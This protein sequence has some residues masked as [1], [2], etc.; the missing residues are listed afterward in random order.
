MPVTVVIA[1]YNRADYLP[2]AIDSALAQSYGPLEIIVVDDGS[3]DATR[4][5]AMRYGASVTYVWQSN[6]ERGA[7]RNHG[8]RRAQGEL[9]VFLDSDD[10]WVPE[11]LGRDIDVLRQRPEVGL[12]YSDT[13]VVDAARQPLRRVRRRGHEGWVTTALMRENFV[14]PSTAVIRTALMREIGGFLE[15]RE[16][17]GAEDWE[18]WVRLSTRTQFGYVAD[19]TTWYRVHGGNSVGSAARVEGATHRAYATMSGAT[20]LTAEHRHYLP[21]AFAEAALL[22]A[23][24]HSVAGNHAAARLWLL[25]A[26]RRCPRVVGNWRFGYTLLHS[27]H[28]ALSAILRAVRTRARTPPVT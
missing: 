2:E 23:T 16:L 4:E 26:A 17:A 13:L 24:A 1:T 9:V 14:T 27:L 19:A 10:G 22:S 28:P 18:A 20:Y 11:K 8:L 3:T 6:A 5:V 25:R 7:A 15:D 21:R 12:V